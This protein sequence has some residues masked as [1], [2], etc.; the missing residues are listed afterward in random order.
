MTL[1]TSC[2][3]P[4]GSD[5]SD[6]VLTDSLPPR[7]EWLAPPAGAVVDSAVVL[8]AR[9][10]DDQGIYRVSFYIAG[11]E[12][13]A[14]L[15]DSAQGVYSYRW[16]ARRYPAGPYPLLGRVWDDARQIGSTHVRVVYVQ[17]Y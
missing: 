9:A 4:A 2:R 14:E 3:G 8:Q 6:A 1:L 13:P 15:T 7:I 16:Q 11:F 17:H 5:G 10:A 12:F